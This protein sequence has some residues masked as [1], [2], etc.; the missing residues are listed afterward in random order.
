M[1][2]AQTTVS[3]GCNWQFGNLLHLE[4]ATDR[5]VQKGPLLC[6]RMAGPRPGPNL[7]SLFDCQLDVD[8]PGLFALQDGLEAS[9]KTLF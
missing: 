3:G 1:P 7:F 6:K 8:G 5:I 4:R 9:H 2:L